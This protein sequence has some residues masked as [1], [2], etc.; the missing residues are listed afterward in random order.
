MSNDE[1]LPKRNPGSASLPEIPPN[2][3]GDET[4]VAETTPATGPL[5]TW[6]P[7]DSK[8]TSHYCK[9]CRVVR[10]A[11]GKLDAQ[12]CPGAYKSGIKPVYVKELPLKTKT[13]AKPTHTG[14]KPVA[15]RSDKER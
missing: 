1:I 11:N 3:P 7:V 12:V 9:V 4:S 13:A 10:Y 8:V 14:H 15:V 5:H 6:I 2:P